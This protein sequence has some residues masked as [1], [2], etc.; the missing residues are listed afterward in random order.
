MTLVVLGALITGEGGSG[1]Q[2]QVVLAAVGRGG[3]SAI[4]ERLGSLPTVIE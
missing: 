4:S 3:H 1:D 2:G